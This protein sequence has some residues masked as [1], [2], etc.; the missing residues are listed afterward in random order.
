[1]SLVVF[2]LPRI[3]RPIALTRIVSAL[4]AMHIEAR[5]LCTSIGLTAQSLLAQRRACVEPLFEHAVK[6][7][8]LQLLT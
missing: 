6:T 8:A 4:A 2:G 5:P 3:A 7:V 1:M